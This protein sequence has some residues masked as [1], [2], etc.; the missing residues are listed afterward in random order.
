[1]SGKG[2][3]LKGRVE[4]AAGALTDDDELKREGKVDQKAGK[5]KQAAEDVKD[6]V[7]DKV[8]DATDRAK[9]N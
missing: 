6:W 7:G 9:R 1:M 5:I 2:D 4:E 8:D 3:E